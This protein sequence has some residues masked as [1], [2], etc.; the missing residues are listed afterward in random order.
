MVGA[1]VFIIGWAV[2]MASNGNYN[3]DDNLLMASVLKFYKTGYAEKLAGVACFVA[4]FVI[5]YVFNDI[6]R[7][8][9]RL[10]KENQN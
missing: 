4:G 5:F 9:K 1:I 8:N 10:K 2:F 3:C 7:E 6:Y